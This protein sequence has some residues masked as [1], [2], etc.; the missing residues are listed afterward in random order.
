MDRFLKKRRSNE[1]VQTSGP[2]SK[3][4]EKQDINGN[5]MNVRKRKR[6]ESNGKSHI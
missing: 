5:T 3:S 1:S 4:E 2:E 6:D